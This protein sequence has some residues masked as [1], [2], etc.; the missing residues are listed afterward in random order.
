MFPQ[1]WR[2]RDE[3]TRCAECSN[4]AYTHIHFLLGCEKRG[5]S[6]GSEREELEVAKNKPDKTENVK[7]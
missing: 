4:T 7:T 3:G 5:R 2:A 6:C 1:V